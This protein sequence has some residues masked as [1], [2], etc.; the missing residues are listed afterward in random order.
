MAYGFTW[1]WNA[2]W[3]LPQ[4]GTLLTA[5]TTPRDPTP[6]Y[7]NLINFLPGMFGPML[8]A[9]VMRL[10]ISR[11]GMAGSLGFR[12]QWRFY[13]VAVVAPMLFVVAVAAAI[14]VAGLGR[15]VAPAE[16][17][18]MAIVAPLALLLA[19][20]S[21]LGFGEEYGWRGYLLP[22]LLPLGEVPATILLGLVWG[23]WHLPVLVAGVI[24][25]GHSLP[26][27]VTIHLAAV[28]LA[29]FPYTWLA[30]RTGYSPILA[31]IFHGSSNW[32]AQRLL[33]WSSE[34][35]S[36]ASPPSASAG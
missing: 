36:S 34:A 10:A 25:G 19:L 6:V 33:T 29:G 2:I 5:P 20:E 12:Q 28:V 11:D 13:A 1:G 15:V 3:I 26:L 21:L 32:A 9:I 35:R 22:R 17:L 16:P 18:T 23:L 4:L 31:G 30:Q 7:G 24:L 8:A 14:V 27:I